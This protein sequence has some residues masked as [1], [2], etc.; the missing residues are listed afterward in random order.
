ML[1]SK[2][3]WAVPLVG[4]LVAGLLVGFGD[5]DEAVAKEP[6]VTIGKIMVGASAFTPNENGLG[7]GD[8]AYHFNDVSLVV[9][10]EYGGFVAPVS[11]PVPVV[12]IR[13]MSLVGYDTNDTSSL[14]VTLYRAQPLRS[15]LEDIAFV[16]TV[17]STDDPQVSTTRNIRNRRVN[18]VNHAPH[19]RVDME[20]AARLYGVQVVYSY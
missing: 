2:R 18:T 8:T 6:R 20:G 10:S 9:I 15:G 5:E 11:F 3:L 7:G 1:L 16:R 19:L 14:Q 12:T 13:K 4:L 17:D